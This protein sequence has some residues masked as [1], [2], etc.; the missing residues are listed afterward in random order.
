MFYMDEYYLMLVLP[1][2]ILSLIAQVA[3]KS[4]FS[5]YSKVGSRGGFTGASAASEILRKNGVYDVRVER[6]SGR[7]SDHYDPRK[8]VLRLSDEVYGSNSVASIGVAAHEA[9]HALQHASSYGPLLLRGTLVPVA[10]I[11]SNV[12]PYLAIAGLFMGYDPLVNIGIILFS[13]A[14]LFYVVTLPVEFNAS[15]RA[16]AQ[17]GQ[18]NMLSQ[19]ELTGASKVLRAAAMTYLASALV[20]F[21]NLARLILLSR[22]RR[23]R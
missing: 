21:A 7:L 23:R 13:A 6:V 19:A 5:K 2:L 18:N 3:V 8:K 1:A 17:I 9:G 14:V 16:L 10:N 22:G 11:G 4:A 20:A 12:G 15:R